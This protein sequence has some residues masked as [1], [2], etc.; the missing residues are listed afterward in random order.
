MLDSNQNIETTCKSKLNLAE[1]KD[2][3]VKKFK[4]KLEKP[5]TEKKTRK[6]KK[7]KQ[8]QKTKLLEKQKTIPRLWN[9]VGKYHFRLWFFAS[10]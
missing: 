9:F 7:K 5:K 2:V 3:S 6:T 4:K 10:N 8:K 1:L